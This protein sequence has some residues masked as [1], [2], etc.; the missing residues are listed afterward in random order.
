MPP[1][2]VHT[3]SADDRLRLVEIDRG[4]YAAV[5]GVKT[6]A[7]QRGFVAE[8][9]VSLVQGHY[10]D[11][12][13]FR[14]VYRD[15][16]PVGFVMLHDPR[17]ASEDDAPFYP[18]STVPQ[19]GLFLWRLMVGEAFQGQGLGRQIIDILARLTRANG[20][21]RLYLSYVDAPGGPGG[22]YAR[23]GFRTTDRIVD[24]EVE[25]CLDLGS[26]MRLGGS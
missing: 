25:A 6:A 12:A 19:D 11:S 13:W 7:N 3:P 5:L 14:A 1:Q 2:L 4:N 10:H 26:G 23:C 22:F 24:G 9:A 15:D 17:R 16:T 21:D 18:H 8:N 20:F